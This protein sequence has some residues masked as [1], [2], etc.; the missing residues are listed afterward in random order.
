MVVADFDIVI[1]E[2]VADRE[3]LLGLRVDE[4]PAEESLP[5]GAVGLP[6]EQLRPDADLHCP[7]FVFAVWFLRGLAATRDIDMA[8]RR[9]YAV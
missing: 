4:R 5:V 8:P 2:D 3:A 7:V 9:Y 6:L 1:I